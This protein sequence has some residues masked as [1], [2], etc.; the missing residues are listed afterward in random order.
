MNKES[1]IPYRDQQLFL[2]R[3]AHWPYS[4]LPGMP[5]PRLIEEAGDGAQARKEGNVWYL[6]QDDDPPGTTYTKVIVMENQNRRM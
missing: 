3:S 1:I 5:T 2:V 6:R 4:Y